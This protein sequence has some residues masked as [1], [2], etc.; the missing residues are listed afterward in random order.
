MSLLTI[1]RLSIVLFDELA[2]LVVV[3]WIPVKLSDNKELVIETLPLKSWKPI[4]EADTNCGQRT[5]KRNIK[6]RKPAI[7]FLI[8]CFRKTTFETADFSRKHIVFL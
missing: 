6:E 1:Q 7:S 4:P 5:I 8:N 2:V 3:S